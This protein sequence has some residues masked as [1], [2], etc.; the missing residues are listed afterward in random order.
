MLACGTRA[1][2]HCGSAVHGGFEQQRLASDLGAKSCSF[3]GASAGQARG[4]D[5]RDA[6]VALPATISVMHI[7]AMAPNMVPRHQVA[8]SCNARLTRGRVAVIGACATAAAHQAPAECP[9]PSAHVSASPTIG[10]RARP[11]TS[12]G[13]PPSRSAAHSLAAHDAYHHA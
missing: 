8:P 9:L 2:L 13:A 6:D 7:A 1:V 3:G 12:R 10:R 5:C 11:D 4:R